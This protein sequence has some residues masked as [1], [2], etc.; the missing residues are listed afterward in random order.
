[1]V[2][3]LPIYIRLLLVTIT[4]INGTFGT[5]KKAFEGA[6]VTLE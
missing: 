3:F 1:M 2:P 5:E 4:N 6:P